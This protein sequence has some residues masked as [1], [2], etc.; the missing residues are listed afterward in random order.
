MAAAIAAREP[1]ASISAPAAA[2]PSATPP[3]SAVRG[4]V[5]ASVSVPGA[6]IELASSLRLAMI[7]AMNTPA[8][9]SSSAITAIDGASSSG[10][11]ASGSSSV[12]FMCTRGSGARRGRAP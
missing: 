4:H 7:G 11:Q 12:S 8:G 6:A 2:E 1:E 5:R 3:S 9:I 10:S